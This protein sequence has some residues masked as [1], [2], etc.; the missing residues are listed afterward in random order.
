MRLVIALI[1]LCH[2]LI[3]SAQTYPVKPVRLINPY[4]PGGTGEIILRMIA[5]TL[6]ERL[7]QRIVIESRAGAGGNIGAEFVANAPSDGYTL[8]LGTTNIFVINQFIFSKIGFDPLKAFAPVSL[9]A[10]VPSVFYVSNQVPASNLREFVAW[11]KANPGKVNYASPGNGTT[12]HL[13]VELLAQLADLK[14]VHVPYKGLQPAMAAVVANE[15]QLYLAGLGA[16]L[17]LLRDGK[18]KAIAIGSKERLP[19]APE[20]PTVSESGYRDFIASNWFAIAA[21]SGTSSVIRERWA[22][23]IRHAIQLPEI[24]KKLVDLG[25]VPVGSTPAEL[26]RQWT[27][28]ASLWQRVV[29]TSQI[30]VE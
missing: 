1:A 12:P 9:V 18:L 15:A 27:E 3:A 29:R 26:G 24:Q 6:E 8:L 11:A 21:P 4:A 2:T 10:D 25:I 22:A 28:E 13:N 19:A 17:G 23:E 5:P 20:I 30:R 16:G 14:L 7:G